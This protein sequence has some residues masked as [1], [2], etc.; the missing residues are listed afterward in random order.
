M[1]KPCPLWPGPAP[2]QGL[3]WDA[4]GGGPSREASGPDSPTAGTSTASASFTSFLIFLTSTDATA[5][6]NQPVDV[7]GEAD[8]ALVCPVRKWNWTRRQLSFGRPGGLGRGCG[9]NG[10]VP[11]RQGKGAATKCEF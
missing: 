4:G 8:P 6:D 2:T 1:E 10:R 5:A 3:L 9:R 7:D 11:D